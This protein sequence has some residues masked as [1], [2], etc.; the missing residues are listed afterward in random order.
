MERNVCLCS[1]VDLAR[2]QEAA[3]ATAGSFSRAEYEV[4]RCTARLGWLRGLAEVVEL[5]ARTGARVAAQHGPRAHCCCS[6]HKPPTNHQVLVTSLTKYAALKA[7]RKNGR[8]CVE[9]RPVRRGWGQL[10]QQLCIGGACYLSVSPPHPC[11]THAVSPTHRWGLGLTLSA[12]G[13]SA[14]TAAVL[15]TPGGTRPIDTQSLGLWSG[16]VVHPLRRLHQQ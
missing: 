5:R 12:A 10:H 3:T 16:Q 6:P 13:A 15:N 7:R 11:L 4:R 14:I 1:P 9:R 2:S 8:R